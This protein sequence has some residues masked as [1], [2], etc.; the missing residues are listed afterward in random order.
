MLEQL[1]PGVKVKH[2]NIVHLKDD[3]S[4]EVMPCEYLKTEV[5]KM[6][7]HYARMQKVNA[8][9]DELKPIVY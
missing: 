7:K 3:G 5:E 9:L 1:L 4:E 8:A 2:L 6:I